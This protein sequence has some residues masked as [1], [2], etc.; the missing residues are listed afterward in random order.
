MKAVSDPFY[1]I[2]TGK[3][4]IAAPVS[5]AR[6]TT[7]EICPAVMKGRTA[8]WTATISGFNPAMAASALRI[9]SLLS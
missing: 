6:S 9:E 8:S 4:R 3:A 5:R 7:D 1:R 2:R